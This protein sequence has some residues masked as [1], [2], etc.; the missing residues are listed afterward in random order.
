MRPRKPLL[1]RF[2]FHYGYQVFN[3]RTGMLRRICVR[4][5]KTSYTRP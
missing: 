5:G 2:R 3:P 4:C 1:C